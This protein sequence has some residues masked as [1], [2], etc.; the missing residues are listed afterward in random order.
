MQRRFVAVVAAVVLLPL[1]GVSQTPSA[2]VVADISFEFHAGK[3]VLPAGTYEFKPDA[4]G[5][6]VSVMNVKAKNTIL[7]PVLTRISQRPGNEAMVVFDK[8]G[9]QCYLSELHMP[10]ADGFHFTGAPGHH[11]H[12]AVRSK[13]S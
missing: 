8:V 9:D 12:V 4:H 5:D 11:T 6:V 3:E 7:T 10:V 13:K 2:T 1:L